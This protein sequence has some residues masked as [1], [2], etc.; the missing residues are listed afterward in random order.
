MMKTEAYALVVGVV[1]TA[2]CNN[3]D[4]PEWEPTATGGMADGDSGAD[5]ADETAEGGDD[6]APPVACWPQHEPT[7]PTL[8]QCVGEAVGQL[9]F[10]Q[11]GKL[12]GCEAALAGVCNF[13]DVGDWTVQPNE[14]A[15]PKPFPPE[16]PETD[17][18]ARA[19]CEA[20]ANSDQT[21]EDCLSDCARAGCNEAL[22]GLQA[23]LA[24]H[25]ENPPFGCDEDCSKRVVTGLETWI[26]YLETHYDNCVSAVISD[27]LFYFPNPNVDAGP[28]AIACGTLNI[29][30]TLDAETDPQDLE[31]TCS[32]SE[33][34]PQA[35][36]GMMLQCDL[37]GD[38][39]ISGPE[40]NDFTTLE[41][42]AII[43]RESSCTTAP[44]WFSIESLELDANA[45][46]STG[47]IG[48]DMHA[49]LAYEGFGLFDDRTGDGTIAPRMFGLDVTLQGKTPLTTFQNYAFRM[50]NSD[51]AAFE[52]S[53]TQFGIIDAYFAWEDHDLVITTDVTS[54]SCINC[55]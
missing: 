15:S 7:N 29:D 48:L 4:V 46:S 22:S 33:N 44:C 34:E 11:C 43:R 55:S 35:V 40:G 54:C 12:L 32:T 47:Y 41:G 53:S 3:E 17:P 38:V 50:G 28:G 27:G 42:T 20:N 14:P 52:I 37:E 10:I 51:P 26:S 45:F 24:D 9:D 21:R 2:A 25:I 19:C 16:P 18:N 30:C 8:F 31:E 36:T 13:G 1:L 23:K 39:E 6:G 5:G 49:S